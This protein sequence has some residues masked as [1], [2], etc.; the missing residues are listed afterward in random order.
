MQ[1]L[2]PVHNKPGR[3]KKTWFLVPLLV[4]PAA[5]DQGRSGSDPAAGYF[6]L[7]THLDS[8][9]LGTGAVDNGAGVAIVMAA[10][11]MIADMPQRTRRGLRVIL[12]ANESLA[13]FMAQSEDT[14]G[15][16]TPKVN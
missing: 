9:D 8:W 5:C 2:Q 12:F 15:P 7:G 16:A 10:A 3:V 11:K 13:W 14:F 6:A 4:L 1:G